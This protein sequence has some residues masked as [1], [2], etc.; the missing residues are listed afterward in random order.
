[1]LEF[2]RNQTK[3]TIALFL[4]IVTFFLGSCSGLMEDGIPSG[5][6]RIT[7]NAPGSRVISTDEIAQMTYKFYFNGVDYGSQNTAVFPVGSSLTIKIEG[8]V[9]GVLRVS[10]TDSPFT[11]Q[12]G[13]NYRN[14]KLSRT[15][16]EVIPPKVENKLI[17]SFGEAEIHG[18]KSGLP[19]DSGSVIETGDTFI[20]DSGNN[21]TWEYA[22]LTSPRGFT[23]WKA[24]PPIKPADG[25]DATE[26]PQLGNRYIMPAGGV[27][28]TAQWNFKS[29]NIQYNTNIP[30]GGEPGT[31]R[32]ATSGAT[33]FTMS[34]SAAATSLSTYSDDDGNW[35][36]GGWS[37]DRNA[38]TVDISSTA[39]IR[40]EIIKGSLVITAADN[41]VL[42]AVWTDARTSF[43]ATVNADALGLG[44]TT[45]PNVMNGNDI[46][47]QVT[48]FLTGKAND[49]VKYELKSGNTFTAN[50]A[51]PTVTLSDQNVTTKVELQ[52]ANK[53]ITATDSSPLQQSEATFTDTGTSDDGGLTTWYEV[54]TAL[55]TATVTG[56][57]A[58][59]YAIRSGWRS[60][61]S[62]V[63][64][65]TVSKDIA[66]KTLYPIGEE[67]FS[68]QV[69]FNNNNIGTAFYAFNGDDITDQIKNV[70]DNAGN[71]E[72]DNKRYAWNDASGLPA[73]IA[74]SSTNYYYVDDQGRLKVTAVQLTLSN[75][76]INETSDS[77]TFTVS[78]AGGDSH[79]NDINTP[80]W[81]D[82][83]DS[84]PEVTVL[85]DGN[86]ASG[87]DVSSW[88]IDGSNTSYT[89]IKEDMAGQTL[90][91]VLN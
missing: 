58:Q 49:T 68:V 83:D 2:Y 30:T 63:T 52:L 1:M 87:Y 23:G 38:T 71:L 56:S 24:N 6:G 45:I 57:N 78:I 86:L 39:D 90:K 72:K 48:D 20:V 11:V 8:Y 70:V 33:T 18:S 9:N 81:Y 85:R 61:D 27:T 84:F 40:T 41:V 10:K 16:D 76:A 17:Y 89:Q 46:T 66:G 73:I 34:S 12:A 25:G 31:P 79:S 7:I 13:D 75:A 44:S 15:A 36:F 29:Y 59:Q 37:T 91:A 74:S 26:D 47:Q 4:L 35:A 77:G 14:I 55:P 28:L 3:A 69:R 64:H 42:Y 51:Q 22:T 43:T 62:Q 82:I 5:Y 19:T 54:G 88:R 32:V 67:A 50:S 21:M 53:I 65:T 80:A 60:T